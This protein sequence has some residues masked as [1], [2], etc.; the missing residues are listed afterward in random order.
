MRP[1]LAKSAFTGYIPPAGGINIYFPTFNPA[2][3]GGYDMHDTV[4]YNGQ[5]YV[6]KINA[7]SALPTDVVSWD[8]YP[9]WNA[10][11]KQIWDLFG[12]G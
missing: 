5:F 1:G 3:P 9:T 6:S 11:M 10:Y 2:K 8:N 12:S 4:V 7:N